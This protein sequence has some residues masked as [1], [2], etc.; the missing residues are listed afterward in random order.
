MDAA[1]LFD[2]AA[3]SVA[4]QYRRVAE[5][6]NHTQDERVA[7]QKLV[8]AGKRLEEGDY[9]LAVVSAREAMDK[10]S[11]MQQSAGQLDSE[12]LLLHAYRLQAESC[13]YSEGAMFKM[14]LQE[15]LKAGEQ[16]SK[17]KAQSYKA[18]GDKRGEAAMLL[19]D[20]ALGYSSRDAKKKQEAETM[21]HTAL[22]LAGEAADV[23]LEAAAL[24]LLA[25]EA[26]KAGVAPEAAEN[27]QLAMSLYRKA[28]DRLGEAKAL[29]LMGTSAVM[30]GRFDEG[31]EQCVEAA[32]ILRALG[33]KQL[34]ASEYYAIAQ[35][36]LG[37]C[38]GREAAEFAEAALAVSKT[39]GGR[40][41]ALQAHAMNMAVQ[42]NICKGDSR[43]ALRIAADGLDIFA[44]RDDKRGK[45]MM[46]AAA[47]A[48]HAD[49]E[50]YA[51]AENALEEAQSVIQDIGDQCWDG[52]L[53]RELALVHFSRNAVDE[54]TATTSEA[55]SA[56][57]SAG[58]RTGEGLAMSCLVEVHMK[59]D[60][61]YQATQVANEQRAMFQELGNR[62]KE[63]SCLLVAAGCLRRDDSL[64]QALALADEAAEICEEMEDAVGQ[65]RALMAQAEIQC[66]TEE[67]ELAVEKAKEMKQKAKA[68]GNTLQEVQAC[69]A[70]ANIYQTCERPV[71][72]VRAASEAVTQAKKLMY[73][74]LVVEMMLL[75]VELNKAL[76]L[77]D[78]VQASARG[79]EKAVRPA[80]EAVTVAK[81]TGKRSLISNCLYQLAEVQLMSHQLGE[82][83]ASAEEALKLFR[84]MEDKQGE[85][86]AVMVM[87]ETHHAGGR[88]DQAEQ[89]AKEALQLAAAC[90]DQRREDYGKAL[91]EQITESRKKSMAPVVAQMMPMQMMP[92]QMAAAG[93]ESAAEKEQAAAPAEVKQAGLDAAMVQAAVQDMAKQ[94]IGVDD[95]ELFLDSALMDSGMDSL[96]AVSFR[97][98]LQSG[99]GVKLPSSLMFD[100]PTMREV[101]G[102]I[103][104]LSIEN[105]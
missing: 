88:H 102:R 10:F 100:Y 50:D 12:R 64:D 84:E 104:E 58:D 25:S 49:K 54:A 52:A 76:V 28:S 2:F 41:G 48:V 57:Q 95:G 47:A 19:A 51:E 93:G 55:I 85:A 17:E 59:K 61:F 39:L 103:L 70:L 91:L 74:P 45:A 20:A 31:V 73:K 65:A 27:A 44:T 98:G 23:R 105:A 90:N 26:V 46:L 18:A 43:Q 7:A 69:K 53:L 16:L 13:R 99:L 9:D 77:K 60:D 21:A 15:A 40:G 42:A 80:K 24:T 6:G 37:R 79:T 97:N 68:M 92:Q 35:M 101:A 82:A 83:M 11:A 5:S 62:S 96:T 33:A 38:M 4:D 66:Q 29:H 78:G 32:S 22:K 34:E 3:D 71:E 87:A 94:A 63:A 67:F 8:L 89:V 75:A 1:C 81:A 72:A 56:Y 86:G 30:K 14:E 36:F